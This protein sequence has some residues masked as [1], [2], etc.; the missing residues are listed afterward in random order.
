MNTDKEHECF[1]SAM[2][3]ICLLPKITCPGEYVIECEADFEARFA[4]LADS[5]V[6]D[7][8]D[9]GIKLILLSGP[10]CSGKTTA[11]KKLTT[12]L[13]SEGFAVH[14]ISIDDFFFDRS[15]LLMQPEPESGK[16]DYD[17][18][19]AIDI[20]YFGRCIPELVKNGFSRLPVFDF[21]SG[22]RSSYRKLQARKDV[23]N[24][25]IIE[26][27]QAVYPEVAGLLSEFDTRSIFISVRHSIRV[28]NVLFSPDEIRLMRRLVRDEERRGAAPEFTFLL[29]QSVRENEVSSILPHADRCD[30]YIDSV[31][32]YEI[33]MLCPYLKKVLR[34]IPFENEFFRV[35]EKMF[36]KLADV[37]GIASNLLP[38]DSLYYEFIDP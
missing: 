30:Y 24:V 34:Q 35:G 25:Y 20:E 4:S 36:E 31:M 15:T 8:R 38:C 11:A 21:E 14:L 3:E 17:S 18:V 28:G 27:I 13:E 1:G 5:V 7:C 6:K 23:E 16:L 26:G 12:A 2:G 19:R 22:S 10:T 9:N 29:W 37:E 32:G 33:H